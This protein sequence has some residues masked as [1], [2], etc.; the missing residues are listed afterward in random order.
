[1]WGCQGPALHYVDSDGTRLKASDKMPYF[2]VGSGATFAY[3]ILDSWLVKKKQF[4]QGTFGFDLGEILRCG[5]FAIVTGTTCLMRKQS[6]WA[7]GP[8]TTP[9]IGTSCPGASTIVR[10]SFFATN[11]GTNGVILPLVLFSITFT[12]E[13]VYIVKSEGWEKISSE[14][15]NDMHYD[16]VSGAGAGAGA[17]VPGASDAGLS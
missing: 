2:A 6:P 7:S 17:S 4:S 15:V 5:F 16:I 14:D 13:T 12:W 3:G 8:F 9:H 11:E 10:I 1:M